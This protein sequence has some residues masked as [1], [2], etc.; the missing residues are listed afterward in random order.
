MSP[1]ACHAAIVFGARWCVFAACVRVRCCTQEILR[2]RPD[3]EARPLSA[4][5]FGAPGR[6][7][8]RGNDSQNA[9]P[10]GAVPSP[11][12]PVETEQPALGDIVIYRNAEGVDMPA[13][14][15]GFAG[16]GNP[17][18]HVF[19]PPGASP[20]GGNHQWGTERADETG[21]RSLS[22]TWRPRPST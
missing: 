13:I 22:R 17:H 7:A 10:G 3:V 8:K 18:L 6:Y 21:R 9:T 2:S 12:M 1:P 5:R 4:P 11:G 14:V 16:E 20:G 19:P 15:V